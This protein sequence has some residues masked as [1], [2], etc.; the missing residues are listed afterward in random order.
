MKCEFFYDDIIDYM[1]T[2][3]LYKD[4]PIFS[5]RLVKNAWTELLETPK[6]RGVAVSDII[7]NVKRLSELRRDFDLVYSI[8]PYRPTE[9]QLFNEATTIPIEHLC[10]M[11]TP[12]ITG[13]DV[14]SSHQLTTETDLRVDGIVFNSQ[15][16]SELI[17]NFG[18]EQITFKNAKCTIFYSNGTILIN[19]SKKA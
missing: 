17:Q 4:H 11:E 7:T 12:Y 2:N 9:I 1:D 3:P 16:H 14:F 6:C 18:R 8:K 5:N 19:K 10:S 15:V 13:L